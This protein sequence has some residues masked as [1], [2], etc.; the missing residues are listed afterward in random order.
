MDA[1]QIVV[2]DDG[3]ISACGTHETLMQTSEIYRE[4]YESQQRGEA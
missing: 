1:D 4:V 2:L 3:K